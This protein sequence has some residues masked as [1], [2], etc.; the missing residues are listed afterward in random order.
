V[1]KKRREKKKDRGKKGRKGVN[2]EEKSINVKPEK[3]ISYMHL[4]NL[5]F[6]TSSFISISQKM[7]RMSLKS[8]SYSAHE[9]LQLFLLLFL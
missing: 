7:E 2:R 3:Q 1:R 6:H 4:P 8:K 9:I 5:R